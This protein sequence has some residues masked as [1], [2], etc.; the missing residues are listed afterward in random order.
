MDTRFY[1]AQHSNA[2]ALSRLPQPITIAADDPPPTEVVLLLEAMEDL[3]V[4]AHDIRRWT[5]KDPTLSK[6]YRFVQYGWP[7]SVTAELKPYSN[8]KADLSSINGC[9]LY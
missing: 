2:D 3:P 9:L 4:R 5:R 1:S 7:R 6:I 8:C